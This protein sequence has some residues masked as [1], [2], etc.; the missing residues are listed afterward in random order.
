[1]QSGT[2]TIQ[3]EH[4]LQRITFIRTVECHLEVQRSIKTALRST[5]GMDLN[6]YNSTHAAISLIIIHWDSNNCC[7][8]VR[9]LRAIHLNISLFI[10]AF[11]IYSYLF[12]RLIN[13]LPVNKRRRF[14]FLGSGRIPSLSK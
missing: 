1:M 12:S 14:K 11:I 3:N 4:V 5:V 10:I 2:A 8:I 6:I 13:N 7:C 9:P